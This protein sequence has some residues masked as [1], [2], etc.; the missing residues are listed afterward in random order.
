MIIAHEREYQKVKELEKQIPVIAQ[1]ENNNYLILNFSA[2][3]KELFNRVIRH[4]RRL[5]GSTAKND[6]E[7]YW[8]ALELYDSLLL[9]PQSR[10]EKEQA[11]KRLAGILAYYGE[12]EEDDDTNLE[13]K[14]AIYRDTARGIDAAK[15]QSWGGNSSQ[16]WQEKTRESL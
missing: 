15:G 3:Q 12:N 4:A 7:A 8:R 2:E 5:G 6:I 14:A 1:N 13:I 16:F 10:V 9:Q 11:I